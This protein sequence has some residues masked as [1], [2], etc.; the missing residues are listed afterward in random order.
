[1]DRIKSSEIFAVIRSVFNINAQL[2]SGRYFIKQ[3]EL[4]SM[5]QEKAQEFCLSLRSVLGDKYKTFGAIYDL[6]N[7]NVGIFLDSKSV[8]Y[9]VV[10]RILKLL[11]ATATDK[12]LSQ[13]SQSQKIPM[14]NLRVQRARFQSKFRKKEKK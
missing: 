9:K 4:G 1:M 5:T 10:K 8:T 2:V 12:E 11:L 6:F 13:Y 14:I 3:V 7:V